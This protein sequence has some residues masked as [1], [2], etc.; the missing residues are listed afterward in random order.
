[1]DASALL[2]LLLAEPGA[3]RV[4]ELLPG[5]VISAVNLSEVAA[6]LA[7]H[8][9]PAPAIQSAIDGLG[10][11]VH[12]FDAQAAI[13]AGLLRPLTKAQGLSLGDRACLALA[14]DLG[15]PAITTEQIWLA[16]SIGVDV[17]LIR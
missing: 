7:E 4:A 17:Q 2:A 6:K 10:L 14:R 3:Q 5:A 8:G 9:M 15:L 16:A 12:G 1:L 13:A 11:S